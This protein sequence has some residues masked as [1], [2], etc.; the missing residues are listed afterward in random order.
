VIRFNE[1]R[2]DGLVNKSSPGAP[3]KLIEEHKALLE[4][5]PAR[6]TQACPLRAGGLRN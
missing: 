5:R 4:G 6:R 1:E 3:G 2:P